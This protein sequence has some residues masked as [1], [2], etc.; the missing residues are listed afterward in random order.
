MKIRRADESS[1][2]RLEELREQ[3][4]RQGRVEAPG[5]RP[6]GAPFP[7]AT[8]E[9]GYYGLPLVKPPTWTWEVPVYFFVGGAAGAASLIALAASGREPRLAR[10][11]R[12]LS[13]L[14]AA[15]SP[16]LLVSD[17]G[18]PAR[19]LHM[20]RVFKPQSPMS[21]GAWTLVFFSSASAAA[22]VA[23]LAQERGMAPRL[24]RT[25]GAPA[26]LAAAASGLVMMTYTGVLLGATAIPVWSESAS[27]LPAHFGASGLACAAAILELAGHRSRPL[28]RLGVA[29]AAVET[30]VAVALEASRRPALDPAKNGWSGRVIRAGGLLSGPVP[31]ALRL[32][33]PR[34]KR[35][36]R[37]AAASSVIGSLLTRAGWV[38]AG[39][40]SAKDPRVP[41][42]L[43]ARTS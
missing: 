23:E 11:A 24:A 3:A 32:L 22:A 10:S 37:F 38:A 18:R 43:P 28:N 14:G 1:E 8:P 27:L 5:V 20:L 19:F 21:V 35:A 34:S 30:A 42:S 2:R 7:K 39:K 16:L 6:A 25:L 9:A 40:A 31:L 17:L 12:L 15:V 26:G 36:R 29:G 33:F 13:A 4:W 41:L